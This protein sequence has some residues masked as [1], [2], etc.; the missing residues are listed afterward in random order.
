MNN[1]W[2]LKAR[3]H[4]LFTRAD[5]LVQSARAKGNDLAGEDL[6]QYTET[7]NELRDI[8]AKINKCESI[9]SGIVPVGG[10]AVSLPTQNKGASRLR[11]VFNK[12]TAEQ[13][14]QLV[15]LASYLSGNIR[16]AADLTPA[17]DGGY[18]IPAIVQSFMERNYAQF[19]PVLSVA[20]VWATEGGNDATFPVLSDS[21]SAA[22]LAPAALTGADA[23]VSGDVPPTDITGPK[24]GAW[25]VSSK[26][27]F[28]NR[29]LITD[30]PVDVVTEVLGSLFAR[31]VRFENLKYT[32]GNGTSESEGFLTN[33]SSHAA[34][35]VAL[36]LDIAL[37]LAYTLPQLYRPN[38][39]YM[40]SD[41]TAKYL[42]KLKTGIS[43]DKRQLWADAD[44][45]KGTPPTLHGYAVVI[46]NDMESVAADGTFAAKSPLAFGDFKKFVIRQAEMGQPYIYRYPVPARDGSA[47]IVFRRSDSSLLVAEAVCK[48]VVS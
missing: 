44:A 40:M 12:A 10:G 1:P 34:G 31:I 7:I 27:V 6:K 48:L 32:K 26:P 36:D 11:D 13:R 24:L 4:D 9:S 38:G 20:R 37:D 2:E 45:T 30:S 39:T 18:L 19:A 16:A 47:V 3:K 33:C 46:N 15:A 29:E 21:E 35:A 8:E 41:T 5:A 28:I 23:T 42:R 17:G 22:Q 14:E 25:K 43:G